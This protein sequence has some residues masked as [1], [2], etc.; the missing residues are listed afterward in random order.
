MIRRDRATPRG[1]RLVNGDAFSVP[2]VGSIGASL[3]TTFS[4]T[5]H[6]ALAL[7]RDIVPEQDG[8]YALGCAAPR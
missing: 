7:T 1:L 2:L 3:P 5:G 6:E 8:L 4:P